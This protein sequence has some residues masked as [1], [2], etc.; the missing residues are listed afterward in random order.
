[1]II[2]NMLLYQLRFCVYFGLFLRLIFAFNF[3]YQPK[4]LN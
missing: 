2:L 4:A 1:M 3:S